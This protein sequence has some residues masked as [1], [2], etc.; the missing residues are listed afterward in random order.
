MHSNMLYSSV[1]ERFLLVSL[2][3]SVV[4]ILAIAQ[5]CAPGS[6][7]LA[8]NLPIVPIEGTGGA[9]VFTLENVPAREI[10]LKLMA[11]PFVSQTTQSVVPGNVAFARGDGAGAYRAKYRAT[12]TRRSRPASQAKRPSAL[13]RRSFLRTASASEHSRLYGSMLPLGSASSGRAPRIR[14]CGLKTARPCASP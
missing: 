12:Q 9:T 3:V 11:G 14:H 4:P 10:P 13:L 5:D 8:A 6:S 7:G 1:I 2:L